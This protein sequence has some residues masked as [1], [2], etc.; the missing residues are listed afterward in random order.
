MPVCRGS[1]VPTGPHSLGGMED[2]QISSQYHLTPGTQFPLSLPP[3]PLLT[4]PKPL[5]TQPTPLMATA[6]LPLTETFSTLEKR[7]FSVPDGK[8][9]MYRILCPKSLKIKPKSPPP[10]HL[11]PP[12]LAQ[13]RRESRQGHLMSLPVYTTT[14]SA[15]LINPA[16]W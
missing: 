16:W 15:Q 9:G 3:H 13:R 6:V 4:D 2:P 10:G 7:F 12:D 1:T 8:S 14:L 5:I 11:F